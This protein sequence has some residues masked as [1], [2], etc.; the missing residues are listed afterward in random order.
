MYNFSL[1]VIESLVLE[2]LIAKKKMA[3]NFSVCFHECGGGM[4]IFS[5]EM[6]LRMRWH[7]LLWPNQ[8]KDPFLSIYVPAKSVT[9][10]FPFSSRMINPSA[11]NKSSRCVGVFRQ[12]FLE[13]SF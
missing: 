11:A 5:A 2:D 13:H 8:T 3:M 7:V 10:L 12:S 9:Q 4:R 1:L 6:F